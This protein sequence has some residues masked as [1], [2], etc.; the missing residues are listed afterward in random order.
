M[1][2]GLPASKPRRIWRD[3]S[4]FSPARRTCLIVGQLAI[5]TCTEAKS[6]RIE[7]ARAGPGLAGLEELAGPGWAW[8]HVTPFLLQPTFWANYSSWERRRRPGIAPLSRLAR[9]S[10]CIATHVLY[11]SRRINF[12]KNNSKFLSE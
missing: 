5:K 1:E 11:G 4:A 9:L 3:R 10:K 7:P 2:P 12:K 6:A 8:H